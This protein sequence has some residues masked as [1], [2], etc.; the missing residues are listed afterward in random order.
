LLVKR[1]DELAEVVSL[2]RDVEWELCKL[3]GGWV[4]AGELDRDVF[5]SPDWASQAELGSGGYSGVQEVLIVELG[6]G[7]D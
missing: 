5:L 6:V 7:M 1:E 4:S 3:V 2:E